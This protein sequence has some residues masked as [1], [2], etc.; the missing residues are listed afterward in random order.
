[1]RTLYYDCFAGISGDMNLGAMLDLGVDKNALVSELQKLNVG[2]WQIR[3]TSDSRRGIFGTKAEVII[4]DKSEHICDYLPHLKDSDQARETEDNKQNLLPCEGA[5][6]H[7]HAHAE[8]PSCDVGS[9]HTH[10]HTHCH[11]NLQHH[12]AKHEHRHFSEIKKIIESSAI[13]ERAKALSL[14]IFQKIAEAEAKVH[15]TDVD[16]VCFHEVG[17]LDSIIDIVAAGICADLLGVDKFACSEIELGGGTVR[18]AHGLMPVPA[19]ATAEILRGI[20]VKLNGAKHEATTPTGAAIVAGLCE[21]FNAKLEGKIIASGTGI[22]GRDPEEIPNILRVHLIESGEKSEAKCEK[23]FVLE[24]NID[25]MTAEEISRLC[26]RL[27]EAK[28]ADVWQEAISMKKSR[29]ASKVCALASAENLRPVLDCFFKDS[30]TLG[31][32]AC[33]VDR[34]FLDR[35]IELHDTSLG[36]VAFKFAKFGGIV[37]SKPEFEDCKRIAIEKSMPLSKVEEILKNE[38]RD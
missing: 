36:K 21:E 12:H 29:L 30:S 3:V 20:A 10:A 8:A 25:D 22:G 17:A 26:E 34:Y 35:K 2:G 7:S 31:I 37:K 11:E 18:C 32:R 27:F 38:A 24:S 5:H 28:A 6:S 15:N 33:E 16:K 13:S 14:K 23:M 9:E 1:M 4:S 19:P